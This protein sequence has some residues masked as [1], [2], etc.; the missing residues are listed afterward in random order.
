MR[1]EQTGDR[2]LMRNGKV[3]VSAPQP[4]GFRESSRRSQR[5]VDLRTVVDAR[6][7]PGGLLP[8]WHLSKVLNHSPATG[9][10]RCAAT[11]GYYLSRLRRGVHVSLL[12]FLLSYSA[13]IFAQQI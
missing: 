8:L 9:G 10:L 12:V 3:P 2:M 5:S 1:N 13:Q 7:H 4:E 11:T 6:P